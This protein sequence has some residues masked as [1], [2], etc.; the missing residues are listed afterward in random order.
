M[1]E[2]IQ[3]DMSN[4]EVQQKSMDQRSFIS[5]NGKEFNLE[6]GEAFIIKIKLLTLILHTI[7]LR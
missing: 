2:G 6:P 1:R 4:N 3:R 5:I 7:T